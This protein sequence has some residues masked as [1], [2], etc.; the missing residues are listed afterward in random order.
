MTDISA[1]IQLARKQEDNDVL[2]EMIV[3]GWKIEVFKCDKS[4]VLGMTV[5][6]RKNEEQEVDLFIELPKV[7]RD[8]EGVLN[9]LDVR[10]S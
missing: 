4:G 8:E 10:I 9:P 1:L 7:E 2:A 6:N 3:D 5:Y